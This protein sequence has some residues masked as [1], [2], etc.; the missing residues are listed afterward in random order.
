MRIIDAHVH[1]SRIASFEDC[2]GR[3]SLVDYSKQGYLSEAAANGVTGSVC[4]GLT[5]R[6]PGG[7]PDDGARTPMPA[8]MADTANPAD[9]ADLANPA[10]RA[11][12]A[13]PADRADLANLVDRANLPDMADRANLLSKLPQGM[14]VCLGVNPHTLDKRSLDEIEHLITGCASVV[15]IKI[16]AGYYHVS[17][18]DPVYEPV[19][20]LAKKHDA[21]VAIHTGDTYS[22]RGL[23]KYAHPLCIDELAVAHPGMRIIACHMG[24]PWVFDA[25]EVAAKNRD[26]YIDLSG[27]LVGDAEYIRRQASER[28]LIDRYRQ[29]FV[30]LD[31][32]DKILFGS[33][34]PLAPMGAYIDF[35]K[36]LIPP[37]A[38]EKVFRSNAINVFRLQDEAI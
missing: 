22:D 3:T 30:Y 29:A 16:Y 25:C 12:L 10:D 26:V 17:L 35:C 13:N 11:D 9:R 21:A 38:H 7:F 5:E 34:W 31:N 18:S 19:Y 15:G 23:L 2:A 33:D 20:K 24:V 4:M 36:Q 1:F 37:D 8:D 28:L 6:A 27:M 32:Y 14:T